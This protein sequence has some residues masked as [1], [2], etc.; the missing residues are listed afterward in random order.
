[1]IEAEKDRQAGRQA[2]ID[3]KQ[4]EI[5]P[6]IIMVEWQSSSLMISMLYEI[7]NLENLWLVLIIIWHLWSIYLTE[8]CRSTGSFTVTL[9]L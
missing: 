9:S 5:Q 3:G 2:G 7:Q 8:L 4:N 6:T 1:M